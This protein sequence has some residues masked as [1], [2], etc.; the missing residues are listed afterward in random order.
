MDHLRNRA[1]LEI[2]A[3]I[4]DD[5]AFKRR[6]YGGDVSAKPNAYDGKALVVRV[7]EDTF[8]VGDA[9]GMCRFTTQLFNSPSLPGL[10]DFSRQI[11]NVTGIALSREELRAVGLNVTG[12]ERMINHAL[13][14][15][16][17]DD[18]LPRRWFEDEL[19]WGA[20]KGEKIDRAEFERM[21]GEFYELSG[22]DDEGR[23]ALDVRARLARV[24]EGF[25]IT[26]KVPNQVRDIAGGGVVVT[27]PVA[28]IGELKRALAREVP[29]LEKLLSGDAVN[30]AI[31]DEVVLQGADE[32]PVKSG[33]RVEL[34]MAMSGG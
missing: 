25:A 17:Q 22:L 13:G 32:H 6:L 20:Y 1:T 3:K 16:R 9:V 14:M 28:T 33:D 12:L 29:D 24:A 21:L 18:T 23:P 8:A 19:A 30:F 31:N 15:R 11:E 2:N 27:A 4:N 10:D 5:P 26:V 7:C 34:V